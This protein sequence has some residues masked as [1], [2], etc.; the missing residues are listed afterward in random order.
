MKKPDIIMAW[1]TFSDH[2]DQ[3][4][5]QATQEVFADSYNC[6]SDN[7]SHYYILEACDL[8]G[9][10]VPVYHGKYVCRRVKALSDLGYKPI[11]KEMHNMLWDLILEEGHVN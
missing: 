11:R 1:G 7:G 2:G 10:Y 8:I 4:M 5:M 3:E 6:F 9:L